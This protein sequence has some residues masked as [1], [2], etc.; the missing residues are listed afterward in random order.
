[1]ISSQNERTL[2]GGAGRG[3]VLENEEGGRGGQNLGILSEGTF[4]MSPCA[5]AIGNLWS[6]CLEVNTLSPAPLVALSFD[7]DTIEE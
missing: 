7:L 5:R 6:N 1:M 3:G 2:G 4:W